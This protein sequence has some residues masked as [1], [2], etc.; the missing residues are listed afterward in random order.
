MRTK[1]GVFGYCPLEVGDAVKSLVSDKIQKRFSESIYFIKGPHYDYG[2]FGAKVPFVFTYKDRLDLRSAFE[3][4][5]GWRDV[6]GAE[7]WW[8]LWSKPRGLTMAEKALIRRHIEEIKVPVKTL[9]SSSLKSSSLNYLKGDGWISMVEQF[10][11][12]QGFHY[13]LDYMDVFHFLLFCEPGT[14]VV[15]GVF[16]SVILSL[17]V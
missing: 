9:K 17:I 14:F 5:F 12:C 15:G 16:L 11:I 4:R 2:I 6:E 1:I 10:E 3:R 13:C 8:Y 7:C